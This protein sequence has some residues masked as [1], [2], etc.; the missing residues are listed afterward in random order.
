M[1]LGVAPR[2]DKKSDMFL[3]E[4]GLRNQIMITILGSRVNIT[5]EIDMTI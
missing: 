3:K 4:I 2:M 5:G 1:W